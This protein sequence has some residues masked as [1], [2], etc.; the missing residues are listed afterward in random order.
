MI[1]QLT[2]EYMPLSELK[3]YSNNA[4]IHTA[5]QIEQIKTSIKEFGM[6]DPI[7]IWKN[8][9]IIEDHGRLIACSELGID[10]VP[11]IRIDELTDDQ[12]KAYMLVHNK[13]TMD[14]D[15]DVD[16]LNQ[17]LES[18]EDI[19]MSKY[20]LDILVEDIIE[21]ETKEPEVKFTEV[22]NEEHN[23]VVLYFDNEVDWLQAETLLGVEKKKDLSTRKDGQIKE[24][25]NRMGVGRVLNGRK[26][27][28]RL[29]NEFKN[30]D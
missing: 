3:A 19:D 11:V 9:E 30:I 16:L 2:I 26:T 15:F 29:R 5:E 6:N 17:E 18:I 21:E 20:G 7:A 27:L 10:K 14:T 8:N 22:L 23:Y 24:K 28:E 12:R 4:K 1:M 25:M 13:L